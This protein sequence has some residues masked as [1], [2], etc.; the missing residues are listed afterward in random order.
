VKVLS[1]QRWNEAEA[2]AFAG[3]FLTEPKA[4]VWFA[5]PKRPL[6]L[7]RFEAVAASRG[8][9]LEGKARL[10]RSRD[11]F[12]LNGEEVRATR[13]CATWLRRLADGR[14]LESTTGAPRPL[15][16]LLYAWYREGVVR[17]E[18]GGKPR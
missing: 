15:R 7:A 4:H 16:E 5:P 18:R 8:I 14:R 12:F 3:R 17:I 11:G 10:A 1:A 9:A 2:R 13:A 6:A